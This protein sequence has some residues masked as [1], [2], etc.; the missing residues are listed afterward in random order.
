M[1]RRFG[2]DDYTNRHLESYLK[3][4]GAGANDTKEHII[5][6]LMGSLNGKTVLDIGCG[7]G[8]F[9]RLSYRK[10]AEVFTLDF[11]PIMTKYVKKT[12]PNLKVVQASGEHLCF[13]RGMFDVILALDVIEHLDNP[14]FLLQEISRILKDD[15]KVILTTDNTQALGVFRMFAWFY[16]RL[17]YLFFKSLPRPPKFSQRHHKSTH[18]KEYSVDEIRHF[19]GQTDLRIETYDTFCNA[20]LSKIIHNSVA[21]LFRGLLKKYKWKRVFFHMTKQDL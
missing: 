8:V 4:Y 21:V 9:S 1:V 17:L 15:G 20:P 7:C 2:I 6:D 18:V 11:S 3:K 13:R 16:S 14:I 10:G 12:T 5:S 19:L